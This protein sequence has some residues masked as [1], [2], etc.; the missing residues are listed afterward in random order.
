MED[1]RLVPL[2]SKSGILIYK[3]TENGTSHGKAFSATVYVAA[4]WVE[5]DGKWVCVYSQESAARQ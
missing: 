4:T 2:S 5:R 1:V 3:I